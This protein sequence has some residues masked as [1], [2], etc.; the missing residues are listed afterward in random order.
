MHNYTR[1]DYVAE[2]NYPVQINRFKGQVFNLPIAYMKTI[3]HL[4]NNKCV[5]H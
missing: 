5:S 1:C 2:Q 3:P 4:V